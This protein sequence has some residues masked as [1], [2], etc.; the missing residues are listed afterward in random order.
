MLKFGYEYCVIDFL[1]YQQQDADLQV[2]NP[3]SAS[4]GVRDVWT[5][6]KMGTAKNKV[7]ASVNKH[8]VALLALTC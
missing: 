5:G 6:E 1:W 2:P 3:G 8:G 7:A 4:C